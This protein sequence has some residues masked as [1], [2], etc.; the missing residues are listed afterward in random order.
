MKK[1]IAFWKVNLLALLI[2][3]AIVSCFVP[4]GTVAWFVIV[5]VTAACAANGF[6]FHKQIMAK[7]RRFTQ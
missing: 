4:F 1:F 6:L 5:K 7:A 3:G 2:V